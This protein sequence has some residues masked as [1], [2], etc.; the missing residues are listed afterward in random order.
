MAT[1]NRHIAGVITRSFLLLVRMLV[2]FIH[3][4][5]AERGDGRENGGAGADDNAGA[6]LADLVPFVVAF[7][8]GQMAVQHGHLSLQFAGAETRF[9]TLHRLRGQSDLRH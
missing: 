2:L 1:H 9:E 7:A 4:D 6:A 3:D 8:V 5:Q